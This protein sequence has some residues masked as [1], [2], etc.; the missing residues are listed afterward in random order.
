MYRTTPYLRTKVAIFPALAGAPLK[1]DLRPGLILSCFDYREVQKR[2]GSGA[3]DRL[4]RWKEIRKR[5]K[6]AGGGAP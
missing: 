3:V 4:T 6:G 2:R 1:G 5:R